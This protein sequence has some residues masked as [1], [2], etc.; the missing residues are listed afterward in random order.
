MEVIS[1]YRKPPRNAW[2]SMNADPELSGSGTWDLRDSAAPRRDEPST[3]VTV[4]ICASI[5]YSVSMMIL[6]KL[7]FWF[8]TGIGRE[9]CRREIFAGC[10]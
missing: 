5:I 8:L 1:P 10:C 9:W 2:S 4:G 7:M 6:V 3:G